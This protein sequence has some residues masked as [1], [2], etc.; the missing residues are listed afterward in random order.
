MKLFSYI[1][2]RDFGFAPNPFYSI[3]S[4]ATCKPIIRKKA[5]IGDWIIGT[6]SK[7]LNC[8]NKLIYIMEITDKVT[9]NQYWSN[10]KYNC[11]KPIINGSFKQMYG[12]NIYFKNENDIWSQAKSHHSLEDGSINKYNLRRD[13]QTENVLLSSN[14][15]YFGNKY[16]DL[17][18]NLIS[19][20]C[21]KG[22]GF[23]YVTEDEAIKYITKKIPEIY[24]KGMLSDPIQFED[25]KFHDG[26]RS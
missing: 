18:K 14:Y 5:Q 3:C 13:T 1:L 25:F 8:E 4:L 19:Y 6:G 17:P 11:K 16:I 20:I 15:F 21:K 9:F 24:S 22:P 10:P 23:R 12:D 7:Q 26:K 2:A